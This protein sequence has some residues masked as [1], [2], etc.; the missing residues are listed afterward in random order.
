LRGLTQ[1]APRTGQDDLEFFGV[2]TG[3]LLG[4]RLRPNSMA[5]SGR[6][7]PRSQSAIRASSGD[8]LPI[9]R[10]ARSSDRACAQSPQW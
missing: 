2:V 8:L 1:V 7:T 5:R 4:F 6:P 9:R 3:E 10:A